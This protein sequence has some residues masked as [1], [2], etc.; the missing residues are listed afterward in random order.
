M[1]DTFADRQVDRCDLVGGEEN[2]AR[3]VVSVRPA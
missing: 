3:D 2:S 1:T